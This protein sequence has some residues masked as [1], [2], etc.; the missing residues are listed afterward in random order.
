MIEYALDSNWKRHPGPATRAAKTPGSCESEGVRKANRQIEWQTRK[1]QRIYANEPKLFCCNDKIPP[2]ERIV[3]DDN[4]SIYPVCQLTTQLSCI[5]VN[6]WRRIA[7]P[8]HRSYLELDF[9]IGMHLER[10]QLTFDF[11]INDND[12]NSMQ[13]IC[14]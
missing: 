3:D 8:R 11:R 13:A 5:P 7:K 4:D 14:S 12:Y 9:Q 2:Q 10:G 6:L 1:G